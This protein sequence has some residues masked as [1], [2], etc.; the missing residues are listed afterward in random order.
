MPAYN[1]KSRFAGS[2][3]SGE[4]AQT[5]RP[6]RKHPTKVGDTLYLFTGM[7]TKQ[8]RRLRECTC[9]SV[10]PIEIIPSGI[11]LNGRMLS[12]PETLVVMMKDGFDSIAAFYDFFREHYGIPCELEL[13]KWGPKEAESDA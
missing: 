12:T 1:F 13:I 9:I 7:R 11:K 10:E 4:K 8:C 6:M 5:I 2:V 3:E